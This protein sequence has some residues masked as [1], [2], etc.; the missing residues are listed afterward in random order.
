VEQRLE[1]I[2]LGCIDNNPSSQKMLYNYCFVQMM[3]VCLRYHHN[4]DDAAASY[5]EAMYKV[6][7]KIDQYKQEGEFLGWV[8]RIVVNTCLNALRKAARFTT[9]PAKPETESIHI[10]PDAYSQLN[11][12]EVLQLIQALPAASAL[13]FNLYV[14]EGYTHEQIASQLGISS[15][16]SKWH[17]SHA[18]NVLK[19]KIKSM[20][21]DENFKNA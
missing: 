9:M 3:Q 7:S 11:H 14:M 13:V 2:I 6:L 19:G 20:Q 16:T 21:Q 10:N 4:M 18:R 17:L 8:R 5:N 12:K 1:N 15:G